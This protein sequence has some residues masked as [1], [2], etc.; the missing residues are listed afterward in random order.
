MAD[1]MRIVSVG[2]HRL[3]ATVL[4]DG[5][6]AV[7]IEPSF[8]GCAGD[9]AQIAETLSADTTVVLY[10]RAPYGASSPARNARTPAAIA[11]DLD[12]L[13]RELAVTGPLVLVG[14]SAA[15]GGRSSASGGRSTGSPPA[16]R[17]CRRAASAAGR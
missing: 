5:V 7:V 17:R 11:A 4:G 12:G 2:R 14:H 9:W 3:S 8:G 10:D 6:P 15:T 13:L 1:G 16:V